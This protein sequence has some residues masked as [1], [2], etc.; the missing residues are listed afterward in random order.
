M[1]FRLFSFFVLKKRIAQQVVVFLK[2][3]ALDFVQIVDMQNET[4]ILSFK[5][6]CLR[7]AAFI[8]NC[9]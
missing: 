5:A 3:I 9:V 7:R 8:F 1:V 6:D 4:D 2:I